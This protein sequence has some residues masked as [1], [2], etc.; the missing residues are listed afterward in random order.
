MLTLSY[1]LQSAALE[2]CPSGWDRPAVFVTRGDT[3][4]RYQLDA[5]SNAVFVYSEWMELHSALQKSNNHPVP[6]R[7]MA[8]TVQRNL[9]RADT[10]TTQLSMTSKEVQV[11]FFKHGT[12]DTLRPPPPPPI[13]N[14]MPP[15]QAA[16]RD[17]SRK[18][19]RRD[20]DENEKDGKRRRS[21]SRDRSPSKN[22]T[23]VYSEQH[24]TKAPLSIEYRQGADA[25]DSNE[26]RDKFGRKL[27]GMIYSSGV[28]ELDD[29][30]RER[31]RK[32]IDDHVHDRP[33]RK[34]LPEFWL[35]P[36]KDLRYMD[37]KRHEAIY[38]GGAD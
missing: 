31:L 5:C 1:A 16:S 28:Y 8:D 7:F 22:D 26:S 11:D 9:G 36:T 30:S 34:P 24:M 27:T 35:G 21:R 14:G 6:S 10:Y 32:R 37:G 25:E 38:V 13:P 20:G 3:H 12:A 29:E 33:A 18:S 15:Q 19:M 2:E 17:E 4:E 23:D